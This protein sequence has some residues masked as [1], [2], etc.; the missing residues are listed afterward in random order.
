M[1]GT[2]TKRKKALTR[3][4]IV[5]LREKYKVPNW[6]KAKEYAYASPKA[7]EP[8]TGDRLRWEFLRR[9]PTYRAAVEGKKPDMHPSDFGLYEW[10]PP[11]TGGD[12]I[13]YRHVLFTDSVHRGGQLWAAAEVCHDLEDID[14]DKDDTRFLQ[15]FGKYVL[16]LEENGHVVLVVD[17]RRPVTPQV[18]RVADV[19]GHYRKE[20]MLA[21]LGGEAY[22]L[23]TT[24]ND[25]RGLDDEEKKKLKKEREKAAAKAK[26]AGILLHENIP[27]NPVPLLRALDGDNEGASP[28]KIGWHVYGK[29]DSDEEA[30]AIAHERL[31]QARTCWQR[32]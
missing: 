26:A 27:D 15:R 20:I 22:D 30:R 13:G 21:E 9:D 16:E 31:K 1:V 10:I 14:P 17:P 29:R 32:W 19:L 2:K 25:V 6:R 12:E 23:L 28:K 5:T 11:S 18:N 24:K 7:P 8:L 4:E 3:K